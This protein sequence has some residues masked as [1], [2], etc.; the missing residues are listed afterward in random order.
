MGD[1]LLITDGDILLNPTNKR[2][3][4]RGNLVYSK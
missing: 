1:I 2:S 4:K 3:V